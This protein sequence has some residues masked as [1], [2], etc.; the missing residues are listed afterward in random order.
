MTIIKINPIADAYVD[1]SSPDTNYGTAIYLRYRGCSYWSTRTQRIY[2]RFPLTNIPSNVTITSAILKL[3]CIE[4][5]S[6][7]GIYIRNVLD[8]SWTETGITWNNQ[9]SFD[10]YPGTRFY[11]SAYPGWESYDITSYIQDQFDLGV[12]ADFMM[13]CDELGPGCVDAGFTSKEH[14]NIANRPYLEVT[15][16]KVIIEAIEAT[17]VAIQCQELCDA[18]IDITWKN[19]GDISGNFTPAIMVSNVR[20]TPY[21]TQSLAAGATVKKRFTLTGL[22]A[23]TYNVESD[24]RGQTIPIVVTRIGE[25]PVEP[26]IEPPIGKDNTGLLL[27]GIG[28]IGMILLSKKK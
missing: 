26:P 23:G 22:V 14:T 1:K 11:K 16:G 13:Q 4:S 25:P 10:T 3:Y 7:T 17:P 6:Y 27:I 24:P 8:R 28:L 20:I 15:Y 18:V 19:T 9:P 21:P 12:N 2:I 5:A